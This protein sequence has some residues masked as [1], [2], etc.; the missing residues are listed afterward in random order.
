MPLWLA[1]SLP[2]TPARS[3]VTVTGARCSATSM[4][5]WSN[6]RLRNVE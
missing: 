1:P 5:S 6:A 4:S 2:V 3:S